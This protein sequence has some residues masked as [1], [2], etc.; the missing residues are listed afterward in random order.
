MFQTM[1]TNKISMPASF[2]SV[3]KE[4]ENAHDVYPGNQKIKKSSSGVLPQPCLIS[5]FMC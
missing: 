5:T 3:Q 1:P 4:D 2:S